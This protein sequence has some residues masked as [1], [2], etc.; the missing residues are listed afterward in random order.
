MQNTNDLH[1]SEMHASEV[2]TCKRCAGGG[3]LATKT[4]KAADVTKDSIPWK[5]VTMEDQRAAN[6]LPTDCPACGGFGKVK[7]EDKKK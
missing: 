1:P 7:K 6:F 4:G 2:E 3:K 5:N